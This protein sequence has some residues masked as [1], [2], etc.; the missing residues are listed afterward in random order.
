MASKNEGKKIHRIISYL[1]IAQTLFMIFAGFNFLYNSEV[2]EVARIVTTALLFINAAGYLIL[3]FLVKRLKP[4]IFF[5]I[6]GYILI[7][8]ALVFTD[9]V[10]AWDYIILALNVITLVLYFWYAVSR[11]FTKR[12]DKS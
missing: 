10:G 3:S 2:S 1:L 7:N 6:V 9:Q 12:Q 4:L 11:I 8:I 5:I